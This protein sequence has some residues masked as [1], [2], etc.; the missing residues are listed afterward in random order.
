ML[1]NFVKIYVLYSTESD[2]GGKLIQIEIFYRKI[3][4]YI[5]PFSAELR[6]FRQNQTHFFG[7]YLQHVIYS[8]INKM[9]TLSTRRT[10]FSSRRSTRKSQ[11]GP[12][13]ITYDIYCVNF[14]DNG[15]KAVREEFIKQIKLGLRRF[16]FVIDLDTELEDA[17]VAN[18]LST[19]LSNKLKKGEQR[20]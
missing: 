19:R 20:I 10:D 18:Q 16:L 7:L 11:V 9:S 8:K 15:L 12:A 3:F 1:S 4:N 6:V 5:C 17:R 2:S 14:Y 13:A